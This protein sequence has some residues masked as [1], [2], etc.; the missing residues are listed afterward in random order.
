MDHANITFLFSHAL[1]G[2]PLVRSEVTLGIGRFLACRQAMVQG[3]MPQVNQDLHETTATSTPGGGQEAIQVVG[4]KDGGGWGERA[5]VWYGSEGNEVCWWRWWSTFALLP[6]YSQVSNGIGIAPLPALLSPC[7]TFAH[8]VRT[9]T[10]FLALFLPYLYNLVHSSPPFSPIPLRAR[11][12]PPPC[13]PP[14]THLH[15]HT[16]PQ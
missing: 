8:I 14:S 13:Y 2:S 7:K 5:W 12:P 10:L 9:C 6:R 16:N 11:L 15:H 1:D 4:G 3:I